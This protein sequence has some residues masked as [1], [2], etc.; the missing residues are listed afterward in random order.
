L[1]SGKGEENFFWALK[2]TPETSRWSSRMPAL[3]VFQISFFVYAGASAVHAR[4]KV[5]AKFLRPGPL[6]VL[7]ISQKRNRPL[8]L[9]SKSGKDHRGKPG[10][11][12]L[13]VS[14]FQTLLIFPPSI[15]DKGSRRVQSQLGQQDR[16]DLAGNNDSLE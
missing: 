2:S 11:F 13:L 9:P 1:W 6:R 10:S 15:H 7:R 5:P 14:Q 3:G 4:P 8:S 12:K 16:A